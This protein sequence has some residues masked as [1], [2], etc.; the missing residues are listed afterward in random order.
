MALREGDYLKEI[1]DYI[2][3]NL[4]S[5]YKTDE[6]RFMLMKK[7]YSRSAI[8]KGF[9]IV[10]QQMASP[11]PV[12]AIPNVVIMGSKEEGPVREKKPGFFSKIAK[13][14][15]KDSSESKYGKDETV[16]VD[17]SGTLVKHA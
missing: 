9:R 8:E 12:K 4:D 10:Q 17:K 16:Q 15:K 6:L 11:K 7:G 13:F 14:F 1:V 3:D 2:K 5:G